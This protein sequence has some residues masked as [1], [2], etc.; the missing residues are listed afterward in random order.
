MLPSLLYNFNTPAVLV[1]VGFAAYIKISQDIKSLKDG[2]KSLK[3]EL[4]DAIKEHG[5]AIKSLNVQHEDAIKSLKEEHGD[6]IKEHGDAI[7]SLKE[8]HEDA[9]KSLKEEHG[10]AI[11][12]HGD[13]IKSLKEEHEDAIKSLKEEHEDAIKSLKEEHE[14][15]IKSLKEEHGDAIKSLKEEHEVA[16]NSLKDDIANLNQKN[17]QQHAKTT[18]ECDEAKELSCRTE[19][20]RQAG[21]VAHQKDIESHLNRIVKLEKNLDHATKFCEE[22]GKIMASTYREIKETRRRTTDGEVI[23]IVDCW[24][25]NQI[26]DKNS[27]LRN[28]AEHPKR[29]FELARHS[30]FVPLCDNAHSLTCRCVQCPPE[31]LNFK[32]VVTVAKV[33][34]AE[35]KKRNTQNHSVDMDE[36]NSS[37]NKCLKNVTNLDSSRDENWHAA[38]HSHGEKVAKKQRTHF[39]ELRTPIKYSPLRDLTP[40]NGRL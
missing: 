40:R 5:D 7:K 36:M 8:E 34:Q 33:F 22:S 2:I 18:K 15:A 11:K 20:N 24:L 38:A 19:K 4:G 16:I 37:L 14:D 39:N 32:A 23:D 25:T 13:A 30:K 29:L 9:I 3:E 1:A 17:E 6:A 27:P 31:H 12:E 35:K 26:V 21:A 28:G 10:D